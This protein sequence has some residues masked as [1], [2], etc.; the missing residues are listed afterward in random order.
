MI[1]M[2]NQSLHYLDI[3]FVS[4]LGKLICVSFY[5]ENEKIIPALIGFKSAVTADPKASNPFCNAEVGICDV[6]RFIFS[7]II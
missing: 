3:K 4:N 1:L 2:N 7:I 5:K 6:F